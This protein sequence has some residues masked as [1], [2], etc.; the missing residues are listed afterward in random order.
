[1]KIQAV[2]ASNQ[3]NPSQT[4]RIPRPSG[5]EFRDALDDAAGGASAYVVRR[6]DTLSHVVARQLRASGQPVTNGAIYRGVA[7]VAEANGIDNPDLIFVGQ[8]INLGALAAP[9]HPADV[10]VRVSR[11]VPPLEQPRL[12]PTLAPAPAAA[13]TPTLKRT[14]AP[15]QPNLNPPITPTSE[16]RASLATRPA[17]E[18]PWRSLLGSG[19]RLTSEFGIRRDPISGHI[20]YHN[21][22]DLAAVRGTPI[23]PLAAGRVVYSGR[24]QGFGNVVVVRHSDG[25]ETLYGH[26]AANL[27]STGE[28]V[29]GDTVIA[30]VG[31]TGRST[32]PHLH[33]EVRRHGR[34]VDPIPYVTG[35][36]F[37]VAST[38]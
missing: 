15:S 30:S 23:T 17:V 3:H 25:V 12:T 26:N 19:A 7:R 5:T 22:I 28:R 1:M 13:P 37:N 32:G 16:P 24:Q 18:S 8:A 6:G 35:R 34:T 10:Q 4:S 11:S 29:S 9:R 14:E 21:G 20:R 31:T 36:R 2:S 38:R 27:V 33:F